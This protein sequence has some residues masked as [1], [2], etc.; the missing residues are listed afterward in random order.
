M[1]IVMGMQKLM[2][3]STS[4]K[5]GFTAAAGFAR[6]GYTR[7]GSSK[8]FGGVYQK[9]FTREGWKISRGRY[10]RPTN[11]QTTA[12]QEWRAVFADGVV[13]YGALT[14]DEKALLSQQGRDYRMSGWNLFLRRYLQANRL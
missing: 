14:T 8:D 4:K 6:C 1:V 3:Q 10:Q 9:K 5:F 2:S 11:P 12:Q 13:A 7:C